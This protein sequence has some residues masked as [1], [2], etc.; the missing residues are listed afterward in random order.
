VTNGRGGYIGFARSPAAGNASGIWL[1][2]DVA[3][4]RRNG[5]WPNIPSRYLRLNVSAL[6]GDG[7]VEI[8]DLLF[9]VGGTT[10]PTVNM[11]SDT[12]PSPLVASASGVLSAGYAA[13]YAFSTAIDSSGSSNSRWHSN[14]PV[15]SAWIQID[16]GAGNGIA[17]TGVQIT[18]NI[19]NSRSPQAFQVLGSATGAFA[20]EQV[21]YFSVSGLTTGWTGGVARTFSW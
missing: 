2:D 21:E 11:T 15:S 19:V 9:M 7:Y 1:P 18:P 6:N 20:G 8:T 16:L 13:F 3:S 5:A 14:G 4:A 12:A 17:P 10:Y